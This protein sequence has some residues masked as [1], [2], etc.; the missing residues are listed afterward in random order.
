MKQ[1]IGIWILLLGMLFA[2]DTEAFAQRNKT[3]CPTKKSFFKSQK[4]RD[5]LV[6]FPQLTR[7][8][9]KEQARLE[10]EWQEE[11]R[12][13]RERSQKKRDNMYMKPRVVKFKEDK[14]DKNLASTKC[15][16]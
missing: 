6:K 11:Q 14:T 3:K 7:K 1:K 15:P 12:V 5:K 10:K 8:G 4:Q 13:A 9:K 2:S 16:E